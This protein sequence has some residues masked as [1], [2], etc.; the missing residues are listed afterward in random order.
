MILA[1]A[2]ASFTVSAAPAQAVRWTATIR[3]DVHVIK[4]VDP[5]F[6]LQY[7]AVK[8]KFP[9]EGYRLESRLAN[10][11][12][13]SRINILSRENVRDMAQRTGA[14][15]ALNADFFANDGDPLGLMI[16]GG[17][18]VSEPYVPRTAVAWGDGA[19][20]QFDSPN[21]SSFIEPVGYPRIRIDGFN[22][23]VRA[24]EVVLFTRKGGMASSKK[25]CAAFLFEA[26]TPVPLS[27]PFA[28]R[29]KTIVPD[30]TDIPVALDEVILMVSPERVAEVTQALSPG[31][32][33]DFRVDVSGKIDWKSV[34]EAIGGG[35]RL[36]R[37]G[38]PSVQ[39]QYERFDPSYNNRHPRSAIGYTKNQEVIVVAVDG[40]SGS[41]KGTTLTELAGLM[42]KLG[43]VEAMNL[44]G[45]GST[46]LVLDGTVLNRPSDGGLRGVANAVLLFAPEIQPAPVGIQARTTALKP[47]DKTTLRVIDANGTV[48]PESEVVWT[49]NSGA[50]WVGGDGAFR[51]T[52]NGKAT[53][54]AY[55]K[56]SWVATELVV[57]SQ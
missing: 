57:S 17:E 47:G 54:R 7:W 10:D 28:M 8:F 30:L 39:H 22:R 11:T 42:A 29:L 44:D 34:K 46:T 18:L 32:T 41:S 51:A 50:G 2:I 38:V 24:G 43:C 45:G 20:L 48:V 36:L 35:P 15:I 3:P 52:G 56:G 14:L 16:T 33:Y 1:A 19:G 26:K 25:R 23:S 31:L 55:A 40:R 12:V 37:D 13:Y 6:P 53:V 21:Y 5:N 9:A 49:C 27:G 4:E